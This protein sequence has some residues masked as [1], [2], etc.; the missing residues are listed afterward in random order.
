MCGFVG[1]LRMWVFSWEYEW[2]FIFSFLGGMLMYFLAI[3]LSHMRT[4]SI[5]RSTICLHVRGSQWPPLRHKSVFGGWKK[6]FQ[7]NLLMY[8]AS[9]MLWCD[10]EWKVC[11]DI[12]WGE[13]NT[14]WGP[15]KSISLRFLIG[16]KFDSDHLIVFPSMNYVLNKL[17]KQID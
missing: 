6:N 10:T 12:I 16:I 8:L 11:F 15:H 7:V 13:P 3:Q 5:A 1:F 4:L 14:Y 2:H 17:R 9:Q